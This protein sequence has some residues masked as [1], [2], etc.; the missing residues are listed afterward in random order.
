[1]AAHSYVPDRVSDAAETSSDGN[2]ADDQYI[3]ARY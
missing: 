1:M 3:L 2:K